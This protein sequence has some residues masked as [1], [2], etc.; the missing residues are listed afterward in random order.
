ELFKRAIEIREKKFGPDHPETAHSLDGLG[1]LYF[2]QGDYAKA[3]SFYRRCL[4]IEEAAWGSENPEKLKTS[5]QL[6]R[7]YMATGNLPQ[8]VAFETRALSGTEHN[9]DLNLAIGSERQKHAYLA[10]LAEQLNQAISLHVQFMADDP[11]ARELAATT[12]LR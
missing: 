7:L 10:S 5:S 4:R 6:A 12:I 8:A 9:I 3:E 2:F 11:S 1:D